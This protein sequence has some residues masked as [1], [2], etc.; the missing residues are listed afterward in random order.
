MG[1]IYVGGSVK[2]AD[3]MTD[4]RKNIPVNALGLEVLFIYFNYIHDHVLCIIGSMIKT[5]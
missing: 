4:I 3:I 2:I 1:L 5:L